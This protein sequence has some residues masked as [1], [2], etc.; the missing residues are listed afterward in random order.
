LELQLT[1]TFTA[2]AASAGRGESP[3][4]EK[5]PMRANNMSDP[6][7]AAVETTNMRM[8]VYASFR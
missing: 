3:G 1:S 7:T 8:R 6:T 2:A 5:D 4:V